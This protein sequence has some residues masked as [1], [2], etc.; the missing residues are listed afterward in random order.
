MNVLTVLFAILLVLNAS[1]STLREVVEKVGTLNTTALKREIEK[2]PEE[3]ALKLKV[4]V[5]MAEGKTDEAEKLIKLIR[6]KKF[7]SNILLLPP[8]TSSI[9][10]DKTN[11]MLYV[12]KW[13]DGYP[14]LIKKYPCITGRRNGDKLREG[15]MRTPEGIYFALYWNGSLPKI[16]G[17]GAYPLNYPNLI[18]RM[19]LK[20]DG[21]GIWIHG[22]DVPSR[23]PHSSNGCIVLKNDFLRELR[24]FIVP[25]ETPVVI[26]SRV[27]WSNFKEF[28]SEQES[29]KNFIFTWKSA[30]E[31]SVDDLNGYLS[32][33]SKHFVWEKGDY[34]AWVRYKKRVTKRKK[35]IKISISNISILKDGRLLSFGNIYVASFHMRYASNNY[36]S[37]GH[38][39]LY[40]I[41]EKGQWKIL[42]EENL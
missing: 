5:L 42:G 32:L 38:K 22:M 21:H 41:K 10:V 24:S 25:K 31:N 39:L 27:N 12:L 6:E 2:L 14:V 37:K 13:K 3:E 11:E 15:D 29:L 36:K 19:I 40:I 1:A 9:V 18:D 16:Y 26:V 30:W 7:I 17:I 4:L 28:Q 8:L 33:Y 20:R 35:W 23:P 34:M